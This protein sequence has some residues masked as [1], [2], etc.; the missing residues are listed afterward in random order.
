MS[1]AAARLSH[2]PQWEAK[3]KLLRPS[4]HGEDA[5]RFSRAVSLRRQRS[6]HA[7]AGRG[8]A[9]NYYSFL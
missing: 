4:M 5:F 9:L 3:C 8:L 7:R 1:R 6:C 2:G